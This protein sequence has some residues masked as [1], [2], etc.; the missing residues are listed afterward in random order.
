MGSTYAC[1][2]DSLWGFVIKLQTSDLL[3]S[4]ALK[5][6]QDRPLINQLIPCLVLLHGVASSLPY[7]RKPC[8]P[9]VPKVKAVA[10]LEE[11]PMTVRVCQAAV[12]S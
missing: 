9:F 1:F 10:H 11:G 4:T 3:E 2:P 8:F 6:E 5:E 7:V 12:T